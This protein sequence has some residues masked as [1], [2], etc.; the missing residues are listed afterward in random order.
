M[1]PLCII[2]TCPLTGILLPFPWKN[3]WSPAGSLSP[4]S[5][6]IYYTPTKFNL[7]F[8]DSPNTDFNEPDL[9]TADITGSKQ[10]VHFLLPPLFQRMCQSEAPC[11]IC[12]VYVRGY[13]PTPITPHN[14]QVCNY[15]WM[16][17]QHICNYL[18]FPEAISPTCNL[19]GRRK[20]TNNL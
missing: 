9:Y 11:N 16:F 13:N 19:S 7:Y 18:P 10:Q 5:H 4:L 17:I 20:C 12:C 6:L 3:I 14:P 1:I 15:P 2:I 8:T